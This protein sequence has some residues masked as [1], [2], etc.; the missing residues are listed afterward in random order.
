MCE[1]SVELGDI[2]EQQKSSDDH[3]GVYNEGF[4]LTLS[5]VSSIEEGI[6]IILASELSDID[7]PEE[8]YNNT[9]SPEL[10]TSTEMIDEV[11]NKFLPP[12]NNLD[13]DEMKESTKNVPGT[14]VD[15]SE[16][17]KQMKLPTYTCETP[18]DLKFKST[19]AAD[20]HIT[21]DCSLSTKDIV[22]SADNDS[23]LDSSEKEQ[24]DCGSPENIIDGEELDMSEF[25]TV[26]EGL[27]EDQDDSLKD[28]QPGQSSMTEKE[29]EHNAN[30][31]KD[32][33]EDASSMAKKDQQPDH[34]PVVHEH[35]VDSL[36]DEKDETSPP[37]KEE[38]DKQPDHSPVS[39]EH[40][41]D[42]L[43]DEKDDTSAT[44]KEKEE[45]KLPDHG[46]NQEK[47]DELGNDSSLEENMEDIEAELGAEDLLEGDVV[48][49]VN[50]EDSDDEEFDIEG[51]EVVDDAD[52]DN[53]EEETTQASDSKSHV[54][55]PSSRRG[56]NA[57][58]KDAKSTSYSNVEQQRSSR[59]RDAVGGEQRQRGQIYS[60]GSQRE[61]SKQWQPSYSS[62]RKGEQYASPQQKTFQGGHHRG[63]GRFN[64]GGKY[65]G[66]GGYPHGNYY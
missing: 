40:H 3:S 43:L 57:G 59:T 55:D 5:P 54:E 64:R 29:D 35:D 28:E 17:S 25:I 36:Q 44:A 2:A 27:D 50:S 14:T 24:A 61:D 38:K 32:E 11:H 12:S 48:D 65:R 23:K 39:H 60:H 56:L 33:E 46:P 26:D 31:I 13:R 18:S 42:S 22:S 58:S 41:A 10:E 51:F 1:I 8:A 49:E 19:R 47:R 30:S 45:D 53:Q 16:E 9:V 20:N 52:D 7:S 34:S 37:T 63:R 6:E 21:K 62:D 66:R 4:N 15:I